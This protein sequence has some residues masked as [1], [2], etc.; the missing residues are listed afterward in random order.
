MQVFPG[1]VLRPVDLQQVQKL[2][3]DLHEANFL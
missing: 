3:L 2:L 1:N